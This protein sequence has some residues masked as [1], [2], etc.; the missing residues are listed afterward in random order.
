ML[1]VDG[2]L[3]GKVS[4][5]SGTLLI[6]SG[7]TVDANISVASVVIHGTVNGDIIA[8]EK[9][10]LGRTAKVIG[11]IQTPSLVVEQG[12]ILEGNCNMTQAKSN[13]DKRA[14][15]QNVG[16]R[17]REEDEYTPLPK[18]EIAMAETENDVA[19]ASN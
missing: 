16:E 2:H 11:H 14:A 18:T 6:G 7:G 4:S 12:A 19:A 17:V 9:I 1:R 8:S 15:V 10:E 13:F 5:E 3:V